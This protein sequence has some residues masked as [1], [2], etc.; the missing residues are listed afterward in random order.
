MPVSLPIEIGIILLSL[1]FLILGF[2]RVN[3][4]LQFYSQCLLIVYVIGFVLL[5]N[6]QG[7][8]KLPETFQFLQLRELHLLVLSGLLGGLA[9][10][11]L[12]GILNFIPSDK[13]FNMPSF[14]KWIERRTRFLTISI[15]LFGS[16]W[17]MA[18]K[19]NMNIYHFAEAKV[20]QLLQDKQSYSATNEVLGEIQVTSQHVNVFVQNRICLR[21]KTLL[22]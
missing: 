17:T 11:F 5:T 6:L 20:S 2:R 13:T 4:Y 22:T 7:F 14:M 21:K 16:I 15:L 1:I 18:F 12:G 3:E 8:G 10:I 9:G 19:D